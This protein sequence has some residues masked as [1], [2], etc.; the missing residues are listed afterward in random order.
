MWWA[1]QSL[2]EVARIQVE[3]GE[4]WVQMKPTEVVTLSP[5]P[6]LIELC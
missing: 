2:G 5:S 3:T 1:L 6:L 4:S